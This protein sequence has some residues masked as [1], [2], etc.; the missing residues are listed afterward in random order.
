MVSPES[1]LSTSMTIEQSESVLAGCFIAREKLEIGDY[2][3]GCSALSSWWSMGNWPTQC[4]LTQSA[5]G[6][7]LLIAG[8]LTDAVARVRRI[9]G[10]QRLAEALLNGAIAMFEYAGKTH[11]CLE[12]RIELGCCYYHQGLFELAQST[13]ESCIAGI[14]YQEV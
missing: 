2:D 13:L 8:S 4:G 5:F 3:A 11:R 12:A 9:S 7:L 6:E 14:D 1:A 10:G